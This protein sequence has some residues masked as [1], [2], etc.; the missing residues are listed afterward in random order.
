MNLIVVAFHGRKRNAFISRLLHFKILRKRIHRI[1]K[2]N[3]AVRLNR[4]EQVFDF[5]ISAQAG[6][7]QK[8]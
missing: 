3:D 7:A 8:N 1:G 6:I 2:E 4:V 5:A